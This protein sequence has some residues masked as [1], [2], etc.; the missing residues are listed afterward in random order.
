MYGQRFLIVWKKTLDD[1]MERFLR[2][3]QR[4]ATTVGVGVG[5][6]NWNFVVQK[7]SAFWE[8]CQD[9][10]KLCGEEQVDFR[11]LD[12][13]AFTLGIAVAI[14][15]SLHAS[16]EVGYKPAFRLHNIYTAFQNMKGKI[17]S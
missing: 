13:F 6:R 15:A 11:P 7:G 10:W 9:L 14:Q 17:N 12:E 2:D 3:E 5:Y 8:D 1:L 4:V 16:R